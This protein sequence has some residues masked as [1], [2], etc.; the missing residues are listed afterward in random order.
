[1]ARGSAERGGS[2]PRERA[3]GGASS[4]RGGAPRPVKAEA[5]ALDGRTGQDPA[6]DAAAG[7]DRGAAGGA[8][9]AVGPDGVVAGVRAGPA[10][11]VPARAIRTAPGP[12]QD[13]NWDRVAQASWESF[14]ASDAP[15]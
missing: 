12:G 9:G 5:R 3:G 10:A 2:H 13:P 4:G 15:G 14:P 6:R 7:G 11:R 1:M 8:G